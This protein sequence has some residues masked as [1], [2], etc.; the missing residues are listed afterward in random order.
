MPIKR[1]NLV[2]GEIYHIVLRGVAGS[3]IFRG[4]DDYYRAIFSLY[5]FN[6]S[7]PIEIRE[8]RRQRQIVKSAGK[9]TIDNRKFLVEILAFC[10]MPNHIHLLL[11][12]LEDKGISNFMR[13]LGAGYG[14]Y[15]NKKHDRQGH[16]FQ[17]RFRAV[18]IEND[19]QLKAAFNYISTN[20]VSLIDASWK[21]KGTWY[22]KKAIVFLENYK[23]S[24]YLDYIGIKNF[25]SVTERKFILEIM[26]GTDGCRD[27]V[28]DWIRRKREISIPSVVLE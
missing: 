28:E 1:P 12:Q 4:I 22:P 17:G 2:S 14:L 23:W 5:E 24:S 21:G 7:K 8:Q 18:H 9:E 20:P 6:T 15:F 25:S 13:K 27:S 26:D 11:R 10:F 19:E 3:R 16:L